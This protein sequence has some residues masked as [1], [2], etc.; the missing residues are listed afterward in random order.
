[1]QNHSRQDKQFLD[2]HSDTFLAVFENVL[3]LPHPLN[4]VFRLIPKRFKAYPI[5]LRETPKRSARS[6]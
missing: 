6:D 4:V 1:M 2:E 3:V 5:P